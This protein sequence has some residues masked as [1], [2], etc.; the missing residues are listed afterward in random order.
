MIG[1]EPEQALLTA[2]L[3]RKSVKLTIFRSFL[4][5]QSVQQC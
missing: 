2:R 5:K 3:A 4:Q 1:F